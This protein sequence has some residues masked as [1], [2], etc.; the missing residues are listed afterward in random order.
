MLKVFSRYIDVTLL[1]PLKIILVLFNLQEKLLID[2]FN[3]LQDLQVKL[4]FNQFYY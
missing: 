2:L 3:T 1:S 4:R